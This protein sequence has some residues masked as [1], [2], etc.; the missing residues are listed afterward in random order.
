MAETSPFPK[1]LKIVRTATGISQKSLG[2]QAGI[3]PSSA[4]ARMNQYEKGVHTPD[5]LTARKLAKILGVPAGYF[6]VEEDHLAE[7]LLKAS[8]LSKKAIEEITS[9]L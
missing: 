6:F 5:Y 8:K 2:I 7:L 9:Q 3:D 1:R 4:S